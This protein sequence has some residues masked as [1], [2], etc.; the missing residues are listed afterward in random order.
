[1]PYIHGQ[2]VLEDLFDTEDENTT[3]CFIH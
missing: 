2:A 3:I 1:V